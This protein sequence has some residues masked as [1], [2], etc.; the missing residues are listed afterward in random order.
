MSNEPKVYAL[1]QSAQRAANRENDRDREA[2]WVVGC[3]S[4]GWFIE[5]L[6]AM[7]VFV[8]HPRIAGKQVSA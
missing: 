7:Q 1:R 8:E 4:D 6:N 3:G 5:N 2:L